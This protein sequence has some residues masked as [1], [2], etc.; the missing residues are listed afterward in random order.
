[1]ALKKV[2]D[3]ISPDGLGMYM[4]KVYSSPE[5]AE[6]GFKEWK[7]R[8]KRQ[9]YYRDNQWRMIGLDDLRNHCKLVDF[10]IEQDEY[11]GTII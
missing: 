4:D 10:E 3:I 5:A 8:F 1:M 6:K 7:E 9:G 2:Y 11:E